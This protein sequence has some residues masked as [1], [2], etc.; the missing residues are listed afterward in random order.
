MLDFNVRLPIALALALALALAST[1]DPVRAQ[2]A[3]TSPSAP[4]ERLTAT[5]LEAMKNADTLGFEGRLD[6]LSEV[7]PDVFNFELMA[8]LSAG[9]HWR[10]LSEAEQQSFVE[11][12]GRMSTATFAA[13]FDGYSGQSFEVLAPRDGPRGTK[14]V[15]T[16]IVKPAGDSVSIDYLVRQFD[17]SW[18]VVD[19]YLAGKYSEVAAKRAEYT[20]II[21]RDGFPALIKRLK[22]KIA[23]LKAGAAGE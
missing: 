22:S 11:Q 12:F 4:V 19:V 16:R 5:L 2:D 6:K 7:M 18:R 15:P 9:R 14:L 20:S 1:T 8:R 17:N 21:E 23:S 3:Q 10:E 13:R